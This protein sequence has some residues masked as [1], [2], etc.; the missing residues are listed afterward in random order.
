MIVGSYKTLSKTLEL[1]SAGA[2]LLTWINF[3]PIMDK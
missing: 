1:F 3:N 2:P